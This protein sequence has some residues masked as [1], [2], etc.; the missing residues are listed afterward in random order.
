[1]YQEL[2]PDHSSGLNPEKKK[3]KKT[4]SRRRKNENQQCSLTKIN[5]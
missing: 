5:C 1:M 2:G 3:K 4:V